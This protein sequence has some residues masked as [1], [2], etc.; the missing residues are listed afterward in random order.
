VAVAVEVKLLS[1]VA[2]AVGLVLPDTTQL[3]P[4][5]LLVAQAVTAK[6]RQLLELRFY[7]PVAVAGVR[8][9]AEFAVD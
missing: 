9:L 8:Q 7:T 5:L 1:L 4:P 2:E 3:A 6:I